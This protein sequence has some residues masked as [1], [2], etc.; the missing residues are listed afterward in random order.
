MFRIRYCFATCATEV[1]VLIRKS[2]GG[3]LPHLSGWHTYC[4]EPQLRE[5]PKGTWACPTC[6]RTPVDGSSTVRRSTSEDS[7]RIEAELN[8]MAPATSV[9]P[10]LEDEPPPTPAMD[11]EVETPVDSSEQPTPA[12][13]PKKSLKLKTSQHRNPP[14]DFDEDP[15]PLPTPARRPRITVRRGPPSP[16]AVQRVRL[17][18]SKT[19]GRKSVYDDDDPDPF[20][21]VLQ[22]AEAD[23]SK[24]TVT[25]ED[26]SRFEK[27]KA[28][29]EVSTAPNKL[30][31]LI[32][33]FSDESG[34]CEY[35]SSS[36]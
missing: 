13:R 4:L 35:S 20:E 12:A 27:A 1:P 16:P 22:G 21:G 19:R 25:A 7:S 28:A 6:V 3:R 31:P 34:A 5:P 33:N 2:R 29:S 36:V 9:P 10:D 15:T 18:L 17:K 24:T 32:A 14:P 11:V 8:A 23:T 30:G 26:K